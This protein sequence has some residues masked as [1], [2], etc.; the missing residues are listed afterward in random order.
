MKIIIIGSKGFIGSHCVQYF[1]QRQE[2]W[3]C[4]VVPDYANDKYF[5]VDATNAD[6]SELFQTQKF[7]VCIN[8][9]GAASVSDSLVH[10]HRDFQLNTVNVFKMLDALRR[11]NPT[12]KFL[13]LSSAAV[14]G[15]SITLP[16]KEN[17]PLRPMS[18][19]G[20]HKKQTEE[21][22][23]EFY[24][25]FGMKVCSLRIFSAYGRG[26][27]KQ[28]LWDLSQK[29]KKSK[30]LVLFGTGDESR[31]FIHVFDLVR[32]IDLIIS[33][34]NFMS[35]IINSAN[36]IEIRIKD[37]VAEFVKQINWN[38]KV[39]FKGTTREGDPLNWVADMSILKGFGYIQHIT[40]ETGIKD[41]IKW[42]KENE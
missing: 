41:Y 23:Q 13:N 39:I 22:C 10:L 32:Q 20:F 42:L 18:P 12:C 28:I 11:F 24:Q 9:S 26:L 27:K 34:A 17:Q 1:S 40:I 8:C 2:V 29:I 38:G 36:G 35:E 5:V 16:V 21:I 4:D 31:D 19:Y 6:Y 15:N 30:E 14:Y 7:D 25:L 33:N 3:E 37:I